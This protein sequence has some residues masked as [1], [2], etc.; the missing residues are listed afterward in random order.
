CRVCRRRARRRTRAR[1][2]GAGQGMGARSLDRRP[3]EAGLHAL[4]EDAREAAWVVAADVGGTCTDCVVF[5]P[6]EAV[7]V[8]KALSTPPDF[9][10]GVIDAIGSAAD[11]MGLDLR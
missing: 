1:P 5:R 9:A 4:S 10:H 7:R 3:F 11:A 6:G 8:G 2:V